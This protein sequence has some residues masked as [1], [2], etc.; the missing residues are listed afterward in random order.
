[1]IDFL[2]QYFPDTLEWGSTEIT[3]IVLIILVFILLIIALLLGLMV[4]YLRYRN[5][6]AYKRWSRLEKKWNGLIN[7]ILTGN[8]EPE[9]L[10]KTVHKSEQLYFIQYL[11]R[12]AE[13]FSGKEMAIIEE[14]ARPMLPA[15]V[16]RTVGG[17]PERRARAIQTLSVLGFD[18]FSYA[19]VKGLDDP[20][21]LVAMVAARSLARQD[22]PEYIK[23]ILPRLDRFEN[24]SMNYFSSLLTSFGRDALPDIRRTYQDESQTIRTRV[25]CVSAMDNLSDLQG[26]EIAGEVITSTEDVEL[27]AASLRYIKKMGSH[28]LH[29]RVVSLVD[30]PDFIVRAHAISAL[31]TIGSR[32]D[33]TR[34][35][36]GMGDESNWV[37]HH[38]VAAMKSLGMTRLLEAI[39]DSNHPRREL[40]LQ[41]LHEG[42][43]G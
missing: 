11:M 4:I 26:I 29:D 20:S 35:M 31:A 27:L 39:A 22:Y 34:L 18:E 43:E 12:F 13:R 1:M 32:E 15:I 42:D 40:A 38:A 36:L 5:Q 17:D 3:L 23:F 41:V 24:W 30:H 6:A 33:E 9:R 10:L 19:I 21:P 25:A 8:M 16:K 28:D 14:L 37:A 7:Q 2:N